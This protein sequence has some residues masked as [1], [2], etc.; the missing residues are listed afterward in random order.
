MYF[1]F[2]FRIMADAKA[3]T[4]KHQ[5]LLAELAAREVGDTY[6]ALSKN[7]SGDRTISLSS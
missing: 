5:L 2:I 7:T 1:Y 3:G 6:V 4:S